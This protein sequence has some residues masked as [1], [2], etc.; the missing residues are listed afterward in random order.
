MTASLVPALLMTA[1]LGGSPRGVVLDFSAT[2]CGPC[3]QMNPI[4]SR[5]EREGYSIRKVD[6]DREKELASRFNISS[7]PAF[8]LVVDGK[9][10]TRIT[11]ATSEEQL[12]RLVTQIPTDP[13]PMAAAPS[14]QMAPQGQSSVELG[15]PMSS[16]EV[17]SYAQEDRFEEPPAGGQRPEPEYLARA[18][19]EPEPKAEPAGSG[20]LFGRLLGRREPEPARAEPAVVRGNDAESDDA[21]NLLPVRNPLRASVRLHVTVNGQTSVGSGTAI[22]SR[23]GRTI[24]TTCG[25]LFKGWGDQSK[26]EVDVFTE[27]GIQKFVGRMVSYDIAA[28]VGI[29]TINTES[30][31]AT[32]QVPDTGGRPKAGDDVVNIGCS[33]GA[34]PTQE[35]VKVTAL[36]YFEGPDNIECT[37]VPVQGRSGGG[38]FNREGQLIGICIGAD[39]QRK[40]G[41]YAG[42]LAIHDQLDAAG[43]TDL[44]RTAPSASP[45]AAPAAGVAEVADGGFDAF[46]GATDKEAP[47]AAVTEPAMTPMTGQAVATLATAGD[48]E[49]ICIIRDRQQP[50]AP[51]RVVIIDRASPTFM[52]YLSGELNRT[53]M[54]HGPSATQ[55]NRIMTAPVSE[56]PKLADPHAMFQPTGSDRP[57]FTM[58]GEPRMGGRSRSESLQP[59]ALE[60]AFVPQRFVR[61]R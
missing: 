13:P 59:T 20:N 17:E 40:R 48:A 60:E 34:P 2:W 22:D 7:I 11:G 58:P 10:V 5:L 18:E 19:P 33:G 38:V 46:A 29:V 15:E 36:N 39:A 42:L 1:V 54:S 47:A 14:S 8:V 44:Y 27:T 32:A 45:D 23:P 6:V 49:I 56:P 53:A 3:Q 16:F 24:V 31:L 50:G 57:L 28:D 55:T 43:L 37:G 9:E 61:S 26:I 51:S 30:I 25:H 52:S 4:V 35:P 41:A 12:R 21:I